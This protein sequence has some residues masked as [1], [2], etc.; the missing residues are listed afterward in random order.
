MI[1][2]PALTAAGLEQ[3]AGDLSQALPALMVEAARI[4]SSVTLGEHGQRRSGIGETFW[5][6]RQFRDGDNAQMIDWRKSARSH[7]Y[8]VRENEW[9]AAS[10]V[11]LWVSRAGGMDFRSHLARESKL[12][13]GATL[14]LALAMVLV[15]GGERV[16]L[17]GHDD[18]PRS[19]GAVAARLAQALAMAQTDTASAGDLPRAHRIKKNSSIVLFSDFLAPIEAISEQLSALAGNEVR[20]HLV[21]ILDPAEETFPYQGRLEIT[22]LEGTG[23]M[24]VGR[25]ENIATAYRDRIAR[26]RGAVRQLARTLGW[27]YTSHHSDANPTLALLALHGLMSGQFGTGS[28]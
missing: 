10:T 21:Q 4:A 22:E 1:A 16:G 14:L 24:L 19:R 3:R 6:Y 18:T 17:L 7:R 2:S 9:E 28:G 23:R 27:T 20:G 5:Q 13:R 26:H 15:R 11:W 8:Y 25:A 12:Q